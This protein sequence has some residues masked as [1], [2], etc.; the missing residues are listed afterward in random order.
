M[1][2]GLI[3]LRKMAGISQKDIAKYL[4]ISEDGYGKKERG[5]YQF[6]QNE[7]FAIAELFDKGLDDIFLPRNFGNT[8]IKGRMINK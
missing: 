4:N 8:E 7:M 2:W 1:Q 5:Q 6:T 3:T